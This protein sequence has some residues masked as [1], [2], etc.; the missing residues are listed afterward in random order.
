MK[1]ANCR[2]SRDHDSI[3]PRSVLDQSTS[4]LKY[5]TNG[6]MFGGAGSR[7]QS[8]LIAISTHRE[9]PQCACL[10]ASLLF[11]TPY[12]HSA[13]F[14]GSDIPC[15][16]FLSCKTQGL[17]RLGR[18][19]AGQRH[20]YWI[21]VCEVLSRVKEADWWTEAPE[22][23]GVSKAHVADAGRKWRRTRVTLLVDDMRSNTNS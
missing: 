1:R 12:S 2:S 18:E 6:V 4:S 22:I 5:L 13:I 17:W 23:S 3:G 19:M 11:K 9:G 21:P 7:V 16:P 20:K 15:Y 10:P 8:R 14:G